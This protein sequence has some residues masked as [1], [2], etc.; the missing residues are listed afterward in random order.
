MNKFTQYSEDIYT[1]NVEIND[2]KYIVKIFYYLSHNGNGD[3]KHEAN[4]LYSQSNCTKQ[5]SLYICNSQYG[6]YC[7][8]DS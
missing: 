6:Y 8:L 3:M 5:F 7:K 2:K 4:E 1:K